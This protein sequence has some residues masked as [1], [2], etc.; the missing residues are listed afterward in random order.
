MELWI[1]KDA[2]LSGLIRKPLAIK[3][4]TFLKEL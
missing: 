4:K 1:D 2:H 3:V